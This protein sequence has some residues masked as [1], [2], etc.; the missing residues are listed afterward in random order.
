MQKN[1]LLKI[2]RIAS[3]MLGFL[4]LLLGMVFILLPGP[5]MIFI[6]L[7]LAML[8]L[9]WLGRKLGRE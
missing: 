9:S 3:I 2:K 4:C 1:N 5:A 6:P 8:S 7:G